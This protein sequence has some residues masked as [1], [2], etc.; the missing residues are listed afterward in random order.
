MGY[1]KIE[2][3]IMLLSVTNQNMME[4]T[5]DLHAECLKQLTKYKEAI[6]MLVGRSLYDDISNDLVVSQR[7]LLDII[8]IKIC[9]F[10]NADVRELYTDAMRNRRKK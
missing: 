5:K 4:Q 2:D 7:D 1:I 3:A 10:S 6:G 9:N 8:N